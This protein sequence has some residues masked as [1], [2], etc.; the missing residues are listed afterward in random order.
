V[1]FEPPTARFDDAAVAAQGA[2]NEI[3][4]ASFATAYPAKLEDV[5]TPV[6]LDAI[7]APVPVNDISALAALGQNVQWAAAQPAAFADP[8]RQRELSFMPVAPFVPAP[9]IAP[10]AQDTPRTEGAP[11]QLANLDNPRRLPG[12]PLTLTALAQFNAFDASRTMQRFEVTGKSPLPRL[13]IDNA[14][15]AFLGT[16]RDDEQLKAARNAL[17][18]AHDMNGHRVKVILGEQRER[19]GVARLE[20]RELKRYSLRIAGELRYDPV[21]RRNVRAEIILDHE[22]PLT[23]LTLSRKLSLR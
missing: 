2:L 11:Q 5:P 15:H 7:P 3:A 21:M 4:V 18:R 13:L 1:A 14:L 12:T 17:Q 22:E 8:V 19:D 6:A 10:L 9:A 16:E 20:V 23:S